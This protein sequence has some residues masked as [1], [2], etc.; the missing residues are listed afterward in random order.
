MNRILAAARLHTIH[1][2]AALGVPW[3]VVAISFAVNWPIWYFADLQHQ[4]GAGFTGGVL[5]FYIALMIVLLMAV[6]QIFP[7]AM[8][9]SLSWGLLRLVNFYLTPH[10]QELEDDPAAVAFRP[11][12][13]RSRVGSTT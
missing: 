13:R 2:L 7:F 8:G 9:L 3:L 12:P 11:A 10:L 5:S 6:T 4:P 1:P